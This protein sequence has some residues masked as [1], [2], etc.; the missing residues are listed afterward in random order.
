MAIHSIYAVPSISVR[1]LEVSFLIEL[2]CQSVQSAKRRYILPRRSLLWAKIGTDPVF[3]AKNATRRFRQGVTP[4]IVA[5]RTVITLVTLRCLDQEVL[6]AVEQNPTNINGAPKQHKNCR[7][8]NSCEVKS[9][10]F[11]YELVYGASIMIQIKV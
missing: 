3:D 10:L 11:S 7:P 4:S 1:P 2:L 5:S 6:V 9:F 8:K